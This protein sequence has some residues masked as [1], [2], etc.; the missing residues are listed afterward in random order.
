MLSLFIGFAAPNPKRHV[1]AGRKRARR[2]ASNMTA[3]RAERHAGTDEGVPVT[4][5]L[6]GSSGP[7]SPLPDHPRI[8]IQSAKRES[9]E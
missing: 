8:T 3:P 6:N 7:A 2:A 5:Q 1:L 4:G 9:H